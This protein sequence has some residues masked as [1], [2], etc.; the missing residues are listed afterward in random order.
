MGTVH[1]LPAPKTVAAKTPKTPKTPKAVVVKVPP[2]PWYHAVVLVAR[3]GFQAGERV[4]V[5]KARAG[6]YRILGATRQVLVAEKWIGHWVLSMKTPAGTP[7]RVQNQGK[8]D[9]HLQLVFKRMWEMA[10]G[11]VG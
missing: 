1:A 4:L 9:T 6:G 7:L 3:E 10:P 2:A 8:A 11:R 5:R